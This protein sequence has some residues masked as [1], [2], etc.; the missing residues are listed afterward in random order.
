M[1]KNKP[2]KGLLKRIR[3]SANGKIKRRRAGGRHLRSHK[4][5][6]KRRSYRKADYA[7]ASEAKRINTMLFVNA[8]PRRAKDETQ[9]EATESAGKAATGASKK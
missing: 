4:S 8:K 3:I 1:P 9:G 2:H 6:S 5:A 7:S